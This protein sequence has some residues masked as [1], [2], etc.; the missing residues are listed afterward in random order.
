[1]ELI[2]KDLVCGALA[3]QADEDTDPKAIMRAWR[4]VASFP[5][6]V[7]IIRCGECKHWTE[8]QTS[9]EYG[10]C[11]RDALLRWRDFFCADS[12][13]K[14]REQWLKDIIRSQNL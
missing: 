5:A 8:S 9:A 4:M 7:E 3:R 2:D 11:D 12:E 1:M 6:S 10:S 14:G 13:R